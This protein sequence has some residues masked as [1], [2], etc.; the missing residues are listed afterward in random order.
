MGYCV[1]DPKISYFPTISPCKTLLERFTIHPFPSLQL[2]TLSNPKS[3]FEGKI[4]IRSNE[5]D[6]IRTS[7]DL[8]TG[9]ATCNVKSKSFVSYGGKLNL[10]VHVKISWG[11]VCVIGTITCLG[12]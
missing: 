3:V 7:S 2:Y 12:I 5:I 8:I 4:C 1:W 11:D 9:A 6:V 10:A